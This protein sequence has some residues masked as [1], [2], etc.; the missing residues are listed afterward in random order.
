VLT[1]YDQREG[2]VTA[3]SFQIELDCRK[4]GFRLRCDWKP[5]YEILKRDP[6]SHAIRRTKSKP[7]GSHGAS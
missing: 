7:S 4:M 2:L 3:I 1:E 5:V 6:K